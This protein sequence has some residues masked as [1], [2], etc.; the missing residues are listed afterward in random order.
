M[1]RHGTNL[2]KAGDISFILD[3]G[4][5][6]HMI[7]DKNLFVDY[8]DYI[9]SPVEI[10]VAKRGEYIYATAKGI[11]RLRTK[12]DDLITLEDVLY[13][14]DIPHNL[15]SVRKMQDRG[16]AI[17]FN[18]GDVKVSKNGEIIIEGMYMQN[19]PIVE[20][21]LCHKAYAINKKENKEYQLW[22]ERLGHI[23]KGKFSE[24]KRNNMFE[25]INLL[26]NIQINGDLCEACINGKHAR[27]PF[28]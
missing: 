8:I 27:L 10:S 20:F 5:S 2:K 13:S 14:K 24:I 21:K 7:N 19:I 4:A 28:A 17:E 16:M 26:K 9:E 25:D 1:I 12:F 3:S 18:S 11:M 15:L 6:D 23:S 22:H